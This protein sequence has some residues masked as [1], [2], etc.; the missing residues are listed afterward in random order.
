MGTQYADTGYNPDKGHQD[1]HRSGEHDIRR[2]ADGSGLVQPGREKHEG[3]LIAVLNYLK[4]GIIDKME[5]D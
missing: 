3:D 2:E 1:G 5:P 4:R